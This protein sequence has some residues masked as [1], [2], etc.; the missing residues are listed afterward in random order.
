MRTFRANSLKFILLLCIALCL[1][2]C[3]GGSST[4]DATVFLPTATPDID[5]PLED[6]LVYVPGG[7]FIMGSD[8]EVDT[9]AREDE[10]PARRVLLNG[11]FIY[12]NEVTNDMYAQCVEAGEC[13]PPIEIEDEEDPEKITASQHYADPEYKDHPIVGVNWY[14]ADAF[15][16]WLNARL[17]SEAEWEKTARGELASLYPWGDDKPLCDR[18]NGGDCILDTITEK[19][20]QLPLGESVYEANDLAGNVWEWTAD[21]YDPQYYRSAGGTNPLGPLEGEL[22]VVRGGSYLDAEENLRSAAR[23]A[24]DPEDA[25]NE[26]GFRCVPVGLDKPTGTRAPFCEPSYIPFCTDPDNPNDDCTPPPHD[27]GTDLEW[28]GFTCPRDGFITFTIDGGGRSAEDYEVT[29]NGIPYTCIDS[30]VNP[31]RWICQGTAQSQ[32]T[33]ATITACP[34]PQAMQGGAVLAAFAAPVPQ[35]PAAAQGGGVL[36]AFAPAVQAAQTVLVG[37]QP[38]TQAQPAGLQGFTPP[39]APSLQTA[40]QTYCPQGSTYDPLTG[41]CVVNETTCPDGW[42]FDQAQMVCVPD[43]QSGCPDGTTYSPDAQ[44]CVPGDGQPFCPEPFVYDEA[45]GFC[46][47]PNND[48]GG[49]LCG[50]GYFY[51]R[52]IMCCSPIQG[53]PETCG[54]GGVL[55]PLTGTCDP[56]DVNG[57]PEGTVYNRYDGVC[58]P[59]TVTRT[60][61]NPDSNVDVQCSPSQ[62]YST[63]ALQCVDLPEGMCGPG[64]YFDERQQTC[65]PT[66]GPG[67]GCAPGYSYSS[68]M[69]CC[70]GN[71]GN[72]GSTC[73]DGESSTSRLQSFTHAAPSGSSYCDPGGGSTDGCP[74]GY[75]YDQ[76]QLTCLPLGPT[77]TAPN[78]D[79]QCAPGYYYDVA[80]AACFPINTN[81]QGCGPGQYF[82]Y[83][84]GFCVQ[85]SC[86]CALGYVFNERTQT[87]Q[88]IGN[89]TSEG[90]WTV[91]QSVPVCEFQPTATPVCPTGEIW[92]PIGLRCDDIP[93][94]DPSGGGS[95]V[96][97]SQYGS[98]T[99][100]GGVAGCRWVFA[101]VNPGYCTNQ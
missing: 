46:Q 1:A 54:D 67:S 3:G 64:Y 39:A 61:N 96:N 53:R 56:L 100:C 90:C 12:R 78:S 55:N 71:P 76:N 19:I 83:E 18:A 22:K 28:L 30:V 8:P 4:P 41:Q 85:T 26:V 7:P 44:A 23:F 16:G 50:P 15:C 37:Y 97:C 101:T 89:T 35:A 11:F 65:I 70:V 58:Y 62:Y 95:G 21:W 60:A 99:A 40:G 77:G 47:P 86:G 91:T 84:L 45:T 79:N 63:R 82:D 27:S 80:Y 51:D 49:G 14:Q 34:A 5:I 32:G 6:L 29:V 13:T 66:D 74:V 36:A 92:D 48:D 10:L 42:S 38:Q 69:N 25:Y 57:C 24:L 72:D 9:L 2:A 75:Y 52:N 17:P 98:P 93:R 33:L 87:C 59:V 20:G 43:G 81:T 31:G 94:D 68:R 88:P 73:V